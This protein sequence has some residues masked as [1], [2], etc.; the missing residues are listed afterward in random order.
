MMKSTLIST[1]SSTYRLETI[2]T[3]ETIVAGKRSIVPHK[4][5]I[6]IIIVGKYYDS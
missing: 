5:N 2:I 6:D 4:P 1:S 3:G